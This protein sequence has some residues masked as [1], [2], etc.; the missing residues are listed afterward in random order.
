MLTIASRWYPEFQKLSLSKSSHAPPELRGITSH[1]LK[2]KMLFQTRMVKTKF[3]YAAGSKVDGHG[4][5]RTQYSPINT[6]SVKTTGF[7]TQ[8]Q[9]DTDPIHLGLDADPV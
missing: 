6:Q 2:A 9:P 7:L 5:Y 1:N 4:L 3:E 8:I